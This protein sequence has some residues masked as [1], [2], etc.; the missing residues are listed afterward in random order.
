VQGRLQAVWVVSIAGSP[1]SPMPRQLQMEQ[2]TATYQCSAAALCMVQ[3]ADILYSFKRD[4]GWNWLG[5]LVCGLSVGSCSGC[6][7]SPASACL[8]HRDASL[9][10]AD[11]V[12]LPLWVCRLV[13]AV[14]HSPQ[15]PLKS[16]GWL[17]TCSR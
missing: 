10:V 12:A 11:S 15:T 14:S 17:C 7:T 9:G 8:L 4:F 2:A 6:S 13:L 5:N 1:C 3:V 16:G